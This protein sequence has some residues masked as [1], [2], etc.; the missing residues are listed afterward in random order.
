ML[1]RIMISSYAYDFVQ[2]AVAAEAGED[3]FFALT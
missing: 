1:D 3:N 2:Y